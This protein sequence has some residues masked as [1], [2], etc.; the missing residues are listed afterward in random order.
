VTDQAPS[1]INPNALMA[2]QARASAFAGVGMPSCPAQRLTQSP[3]KQANPP[4]IA[5]TKT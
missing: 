3:A 5:E 2:E 1:E 4:D